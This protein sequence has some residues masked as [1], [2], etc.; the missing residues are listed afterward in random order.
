MADSR[1]SKPLE[2]EFKQGCCYGSCQGCRERG[3]FINWVR[4]HAPELGDDQTKALLQR[5]GAGHVLAQFTKDGQSP[6]AGRAGG[7]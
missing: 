6:D 1:D 5:L 4:Q 3:V 7:V 2:Y